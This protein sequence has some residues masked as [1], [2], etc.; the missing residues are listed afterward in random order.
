MK[1]A[2]IG[3]GPAGMMA[4]ITAAENGATGRKGIGIRRGGNQTGLHVHPAAHAGGNATHQPTAPQ[5]QTHAQTPQDKGTQNRYGKE[6]RLITAAPV[7]V[8]QLPLVQ[9]A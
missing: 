4:A 3:G 9:A 6:R 2:V 1:I 7:P 8:L 5:A